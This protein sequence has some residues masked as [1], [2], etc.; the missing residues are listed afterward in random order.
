MRGK[1]LTVDIGGI[2]IAVTCY[3]NKELSFPDNYEQFITDKNPEVFLNVW[4]C[5]A[6]HFSLGKKVFDSENVSTYRSGEE[7]IIFF[8]IL[9]RVDTLPRSVTKINPRLKSIDLYVK[10]DEHEQCFYPLPFLSRFIVANIL[11]WGLG[12]IMHAS[13]I[14][15]NGQGIIFAGYSG[16]GKTTLAALWKSA[17]RTILD[18]DRVIVRKKEECFWLCGTPWFENIQFSSPEM[19]PLE[20][21]FFVEHAKRNTVVQKKGVDAL[22]DILSHTFCPTWYVPGMQFTMDFL[23]ELVRRVPCYHL[24]FVPDES[25]VDFVGKIC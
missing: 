11:S 22:R 15:D 5:D 7:F 25:I 1:N 14:S 6:P 17:N 3:S 16:A 2:S 21:I 13:G 10:S 24:G 19:C 12:V 4:D 23:S 9:K 20:R 18:D 8:R